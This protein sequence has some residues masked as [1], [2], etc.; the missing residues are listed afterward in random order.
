[1]E[2]SQD[3]ESTYFMTPNELLDMESFRSGSTTPVKYNYC[4]KCNIPLV[5]HQQEYICSE[6]GI[7]L[8]YEDAADSEPYGAENN[9]MH[10]NVGANKGRYSNSTMDYAATQ[11]RSILDLLHQLAREYTGPSISEAILESVASQY[12]NIQR[13]VTESI[14]MLDGSF[15]E[16]KFVRRNGIKYEILAFIIYNTCIRDGTSRKKKCIAEFMHL[17]KN[18]FARGEAIVSNLIALGKLDMKIR[19]DDVEGFAIR[20]LSHLNIDL[21]YVG[22]IIDIIALSEEKMID[23]T[24]QI[25]SKVAALIWLLVRHCGFSNIGSREIEVVT[26]NTRKNTFK[27][28]YGAIMTNKKHFEGIFV[29]YGVPFVPEIRD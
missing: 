15:V 5:H 18:G 29:K 22:F 2:D 26:D 10:I 4:P 7:T 23:K 27:G 24:R 17:D 6:C 1:M 20:Y 16:K 14:Q 11:K 8:P 21:K 19:E 25:P 3:S 9:V 28:F 12:N 13:S